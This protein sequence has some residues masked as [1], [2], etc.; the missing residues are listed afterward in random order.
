MPLI[1][2]GTL[3]RGGSRT[4]PTP[5]PARHERTFAPAALPSRENAHLPLDLTT[6]ALRAL[7]PFGRVHRASQ[8]LESVLTLLAYVLVN[9]H[10]TASYRRYA[11]PDP[12][13]PG[14]IHSI[15]TSL[16]PRKFAPHLGNATQS[17]LR[18]PLG[19]N[20]KL[21]SI[22]SPQP[23]QERIDMGLLRR[24]KPTTTEGD[25]IVRAHNGWSFAQRRVSAG[26]VN[27]ELGWGLA[28]RSL[29]PQRP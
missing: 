22:E 24:R 27:R 21:T 14:R 16:R 12:R 5:S 20:L 10:L 25:P 8:V 11:H 3:T 6:P 17:P 4:L 28:G 29:Q 15:G 19:N 2:H 1:S 9:G 26:Q 23:S 13:A 7:S 18:K